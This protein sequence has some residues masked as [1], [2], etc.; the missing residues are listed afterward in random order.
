MYKQQERVLHDRAIFN[1]NDANRRELR[2]RASGDDSTMSLCPLLRALPPR[3]H[4]H[5][6]ARQ[7]LQIRG[8]EVFKFVREIV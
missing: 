2:V 7:C 3:C 1:S 6:L 4:A 8:G 5:M